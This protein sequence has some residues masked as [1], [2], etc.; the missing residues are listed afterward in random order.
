MT[1]LER[2]LFS[3]ALPLS[4]VDTGHF[5]LL[6]RSQ[7]S[8]FELGRFGFVTGFRTF[9]W[10][11]PFP[12][13][14]FPSAFALPFVSPLP[15]ACGFPAFMGKPAASSFLAFVGPLFN[16]SWMERAFRSCW[17]SCMHMSIFS[18]NHS[19]DR[20]SESNGE[21]RT[22]SM[23][24]RIRGCF[25][26]DHTTTSQATLGRIMRTNLIHNISYFVPPLT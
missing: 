10:R 11:I 22:P 8:G 7:F 26:F 16:A 13:T 18:H 5:C 24:L 9:G 12:P 3:K 4:K 15:L 17:F 23:C 19:N 25:S 14:P 6:G 20:T 21:S 1:M 2:T